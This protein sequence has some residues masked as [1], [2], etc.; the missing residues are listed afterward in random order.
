M[1]EACSDVSYPHPRLLDGFYASE[2]SASITWGVITRA[3]GADAEASNSGD[4]AKEKHSSSLASRA[5][6]ARIE[7]VKGPMRSLT[8]RRYH[9]LRADHIRG[10]A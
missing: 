7:L 3:T 5:D 4:P 10:N 9:T 2:S 1:L 6:I 8:L